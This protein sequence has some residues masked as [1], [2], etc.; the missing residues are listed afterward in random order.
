[1]ADIVSRI[2]S[3]IN[4]TVVNQNSVGGGCIA[5]SQIIVA[6]D[7]NEYFLKQGFNNDLFRK[8]ANGLIELEKCGALRTPKVISVD[9]DYLLLEKISS[10]VKTSDFFRDFGELLAKLHRYRGPQFG[11]Y[12]DNYIGSTPQIN[13]C[14][15]NTCT[16][17]PQFYFNKRLLYQFRLCEQN[18]YV[19]P[20]FASTFNKLEAK[21]SSILEWENEPP[22]LLHGDLWG[23]N[24]MVDE[25]GKP[26]LIDPAVYYG[27]R[28]ADLAMTKLF[29]GFHPDFYQSYHES[30][31]LKP[32]YEYREN[33][34]LLYHVMNH[35]NIFG[36]SY[37]HQALQL[38]NSY[39]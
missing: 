8:E 20:V 1:M 33:I 34:Y 22:S 27:H 37:K 21:I 32:G 23:G 25:K 12:E 29:G 39:L 30:Y 36:T 2:E 6:N 13:T 14:A 31:P 18:G 17:W 26:A 5:Q 10:G 24:Y 3:V 38:M 7:G 15:S 19:D 35:L 11:F 4:A 16:D 9:S 28:E